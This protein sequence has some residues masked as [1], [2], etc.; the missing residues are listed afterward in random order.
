[1]TQSIYKAETMCSG[2]KGKN[3]SFLITQRMQ[4]FPKLHALNGGPIL[5]EINIFQL[6]LWSPGRFQ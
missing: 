2:V 3:W 6:F 5:F 1:L 4:L